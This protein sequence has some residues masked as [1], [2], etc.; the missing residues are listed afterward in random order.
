MAL[1]S[2]L[3]RSAARITPIASRLI[4][5]QRTH[6]SHTPALY[7]AVQS[8]LSDNLVISTSLS[9][10]RRYSSAAS[11]PSIKKSTGSD[12]KQLELLESIIDSIVDSIEDSREDISDIEP[13]EWFPFQI[14]DIEPP[15]W[16]HFQIQDIPGIPSITLLRKYQGEN[17][18][19][20]VDL[21]KNKEFLRASPISL[22]VTVAKS[23]NCNLLFDCTGY[24][25]GIIINSLT[26]S[27]KKRDGQDDYKS[28]EYLD[29]KLSKALVEFL[30]DRGIE[31]GIG[32]FLCEYMIRK[33]NKEYLNWLHKLK[34]F[35]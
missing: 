8:Q 4:A 27:V 20:K 25:S 29:S 23:E 5:S 15:T 7:S 6:H 18:H 17:I 24:P 3:R 2:T 35:V 33:S 19:V 13:P 9:S 11:C 31:V 1:Y 34:K 32:Y 22:L 14:Q 21:N 26:V 28:P 16:F 12:W 10:L 30:E